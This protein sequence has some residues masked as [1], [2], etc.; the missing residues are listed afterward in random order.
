MN[1]LKSTINLD[2]VNLLFNMGILHTCMRTRLY[3]LVDFQYFQYF[4]YTSSHAP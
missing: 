2:S 1:K 3:I 4:D